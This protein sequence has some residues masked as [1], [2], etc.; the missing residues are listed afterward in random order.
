MASGRGTH[1]DAVAFLPPLS[2]VR[3]RLSA[4]RFCHPGPRQSGRRD[5]VAQLRPP[6]NVSG[7]G[8]PVS[9]ADGAAVHYCP[10]RM[11]YAIKNLAA[12]QDLAPRF[13]FDAVQEAR[14]PREDLGA[15][16]IGL[17]YHVVKPD[18]RQ[19]FAHRHLQAEEIYV[20][21]AGAGRVKLGEQVHEVGAMDAIRV[22]PH[23]PR[24][25]AAGPEGLQLLVFGPRHAGDTEIIK[26]DFW[27]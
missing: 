1:R 8:G 21:L 15:E 11:E 26:E 17:A 24:A 13:G 3:L 4:G 18:Q 16:T 25:F 23:V 19:A 22:A 14:F 6:G 2:W 20:V 7:P 5:I 27:G 12:V 10:R 9:G